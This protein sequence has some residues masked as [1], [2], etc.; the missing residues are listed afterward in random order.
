MEFQLQLLNDWTK[1]LCIAHDK[2]T[3]AKDFYT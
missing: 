1:V 3:S 2:L